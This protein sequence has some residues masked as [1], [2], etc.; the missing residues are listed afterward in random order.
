[1]GVPRAGSQAVWHRADRAPVDAVVKEIAFAG[2]FPEAATVC[3]D[4]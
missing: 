1:M 2:G 3:L 4:D